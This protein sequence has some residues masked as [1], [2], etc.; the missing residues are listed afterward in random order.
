MGGR[1]EGGQK[2][3]GT[4]RRGRTSRVRWERGGR[5][6]GGGVGAHV[7]YT[8]GVGREAVA[9]REAFVADGRGELERQLRG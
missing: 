9:E 2:H 1:A 6:A 7:A 5:G 3:R 4:G 8:M